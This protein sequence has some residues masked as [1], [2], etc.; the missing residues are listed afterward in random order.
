MHICCNWAGVTMACTH[1]TGSPRMGSCTFTPAICL[2]KREWQRAKIP[3]PELPVVVGNIIV[4]IWHL[5]LW[6]EVQEAKSSLKCKF[7]PISL[8]VKY[9]N[10]ITRGT[11]SLPISTMSNNAENVHGFHGVILASKT[12]SFHS[13]KINNFIVVQT[14]TCWYLRSKSVKYA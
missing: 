5:S 10:L 8:N 3:Y 6:W 7:C 9:F 14:L 2:S 11:D 13:V 12:H 4:G 1:R